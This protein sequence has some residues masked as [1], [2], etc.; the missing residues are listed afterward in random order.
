M[1]LLNKTFLTSISVLSSMLFSAVPRQDQTE[2]PMYRLS[3][4]EDAELDGAYL[5]LIADAW[6]RHQS[7]PLNRKSGPDDFTVTLSKDRGIRRVHFVPKPMPHKATLGGGNERGVENVYVY[8][9]K[10]GKLKIVLAAG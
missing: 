10:T 4:K 1:T 6:K 5:P 2:D 8:D 7:Q 9:A 3:Y